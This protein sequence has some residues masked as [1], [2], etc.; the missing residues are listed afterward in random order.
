MRRSASITSRR[1]VCGPAPHRPAPTHPLRSSTLR[2]R[3]VRICVCG[4]SRA[5]TL[6]GM[7]S[8]VIV[9]VSIP[10]ASGPRGRAT[11]VWWSNTANQTAVPLPYRSTTGQFRSR[12]RGMAVCRNRALQTGFTLSIYCSTMTKDKKSN[13]C[14]TGLACVPELLFPEAPHVLGESMRAEIIEPTI[15]RD[16]RAKWRLPSCRCRW[17]DAVRLHTE[18]RGRDP[19]IPSGANDIRVLSILEDYFLAPA[20]SS[21]TF[22]SSDLILLLTL[23]KL[24]HCSSATG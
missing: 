8:P 1:Y 14:R 5:F 16:R 12:R 4:R 21:L 13:G 7:L 17:R 22:A 6:G 18:I 2:T 10:G 19:A 15:R 24:Y 3:V 23:A 9:G 11:L 20:S